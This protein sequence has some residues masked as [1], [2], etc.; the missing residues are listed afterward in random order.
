M[1]I[2]ET[3][4][5]NSVREQ[6]LA[7]RARL[8]D[9]LA[10]NESEQVLRLL[11]EVDSALHRIDHGTFGVCEVCLGTVEPGRLLENPLARVCLDC[12]TP[13]QQRALEYDLEL[14][15]QI[16]KGLLPPQDLVISGWDISY[17][18]Q[19]AGMVGGDYCDVIKEDGHL[20]FI[21]ADVSGKGVAAAMLA[22]NLRAVFHSLIPLRLPVAE[23]MVRANRLF[24]ESALANQYATLVFGRVSNR[25]ELELAN[26]GHLPVLLAGKSGVR[27]F[28]SNC[29]PLGFFSDDRVEVVKARMSPGDTVVLYTDGISEAENDGGEE[30]GMDRLRTLIE[31]QRL[32]CPVDLVS[33]CRKQVA[34]F[35]GAA[36]R[37]DDETLLAIQYAPAAG[38]NF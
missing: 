26:A 28:E 24:H 3:V 21:M 15:A 12:L 20:H 33:A 37:F 32:C 25:G 23:L 18:Y 8:A 22:S 27:T 2:G 9:V 34:A 36:E 14:A 1:A 30:F 13:K 35:R 7:G 5:V 38:S 6:L 19:P 17:H 11:E 10:D 16:Q 31:E 4:Y 29:K